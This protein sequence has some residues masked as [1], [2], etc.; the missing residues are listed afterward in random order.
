MKLK[1]KL[2]N[3]VFVIF[4]TACGGGGGS[5][6]GDNTSNDTPVE[7]T[8]ELAVAAKETSAQIIASESEVALPRFGG[9]SGTAHSTLKAAL[10]APPEKQLGLFS[11]SDS[12]LQPLAT[13]PGSGTVDGTCGGTATYSHTVT[14]DDTDVYPI[15]MD[16][17]YVLSDYCLDFNEGYQIVYDGF[18][19]MDM[20]ATD[21]E[22]ATYDYE[23]DLSY[24]TN[25]PDHPSGSLYYAES[26]TMTNGDMQCSTGVYESENTTYH[27]SDVTVT[28]DTASGYNINYTITDG[29]GNDCSVVFTG[30]T[31][32]DN[33]NIGSGSGTI[34]MDGDVIHI[35]FTNCNEFVV[36]YNGTS[37][38]YSQ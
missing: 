23:F 28:G 21:G 15:A 31:L 12:T 24:T 1:M 10:A 7:N 35:E 9:P 14:S 17:D 16:Y 32:C 25:F 27:T 6:P 36:T 2:L 33:G 18:F 22:N 20:Y 11:T 30:L 37:E 3:I 34:T 13:D 38:T 19:T 8:Q 26:C 5:T 4:F 29:D